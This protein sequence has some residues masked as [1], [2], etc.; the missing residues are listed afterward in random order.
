MGQGARGCCAAVRSIAGLGR[1]ARL[2]RRGSQPVLSMEGLVLPIT[3]AEPLWGAGAGGCCPW[4]QDRD[5]SLPAGQAGTACKH[6]WRGQRQLVSAFPY[7]P[8]AGE[9]SVDEPGLI[10]AGN[11]QELHGGG[12]GF[13][14]GNGTA[15][16][17]PGSQLGA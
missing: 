9:L 13:A 11:V 8:S 15:G 10:T 1:T 7:V 3:T 5:L 14:K 17:G 4:S 2:Q 6:G 16:T 12:K